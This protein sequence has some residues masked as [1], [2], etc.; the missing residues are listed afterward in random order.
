[1]NTISEK[2]RIE[3]YSAFFNLQDW[4]LST[5]A[6]EEREYIANRYQP[7]GLP[8]HILT[9]GKW[10]TSKPATQFLNELNTWFKAKKDTLIADRIHAKII[11]LGIQQPIQKHGYYQGRHYTTYVRDV[12]YL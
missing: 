9:K 10:E 2:E 1:M 5:F 12:E 4:W 6:R 11:E 8:H 7:M 3:G